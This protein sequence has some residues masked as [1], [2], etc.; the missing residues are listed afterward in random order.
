MAED[1]NLFSD[2]K[3]IEVNIEDIMKDSFLDY[4]MSVIVARALPDVRDGLKPVQ[5]RILYAM[6][7]LG[8]YH[9]RPHKKSARIVG[10]VLGK[11]HPHG[12]TAV[13]DAL[14][15][16]AQDFSLRYPLI[17]GH[18]N[19]GSIDGDSAAAMR[20][21]EARLS[22]IAEE[23]LRDID[24]DTVDF[25]PNFDNEEKE[26][27]VLPSVIPN[28]LINGSTGIAVGMATNIPSHNLGEVIEGIIAY[29][30]NKD[31]TV[32]ELAEIIKGPDFPTGAMI[33]GKQEI[34]K[35]FKTGLGRIRLR[36]KSHIEEKKKGKKAIIVTEIPFMVNK[37][38]LIEDIAKLIN[39]KKIDG[40]TELRDES[41]KEGLRIYIEV[42]KDVDPELVLNQLYKHTN[43]ETTFGVNMV[44]LVDGVPKLLNIKEMIYNF[45]EFRVEVIVRRSKYEL[46]KAEERAHILEGLKIALANIDEVVAIIKGSKDTQEAAQKLIERFLLTQVQAQAI[47]DM[48]LA[49]LTSLEI[50]KLEE[51]YKE[52]LQ[53]I[54]YL[55]NL[56]GSRELQEVVVVEELEEIKKLYSD[57]RRTEIITDYENKDITIEDTIINEDMMVIL[58]KKGYIKR[59]PLKTYRFQNRGGRGVNI[60]YSSDDDFVSN[61]VNAKMLDYLLL[62]TNRGRVFWVKTYQIPEGSRNARGKLIRNIIKLEQDEEIRTIINLSSFE[63]EDYLIMVTERGL[64]NKTKVENFSRPRSTGLYAIKIND[65]DKLLSVIVSKKNSQVLIATR[66]GKAIRFNQTDV[67][68]RNRN[69]KGVIGIKLDGDDRVIDVLSIPEDKISDSFILTVTENGYGKMSSFEDYR[70]TSRSAKGVINI[71]VTEKN[72]KVVAVKRATPNHIAFIVTKNGNVIKIKLQDVSVLSRNTQGIKLINLQE[73]DKVT[74][75][76]VEE[77]D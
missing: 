35:Y 76:L 11:Y 26:P 60:T 34:I 42:R 30:K 48:R 18:G 43:M 15:R 6:K 77:E 57:K 2:Q 16:M 55:K 68:E 10:E 20:Y 31:I 65:D 73:G 52:L 69:T 51:E 71:K 3:V 19:F 63:P 13:Y 54:E 39:E 33:L 4:A 44:A 41:D 36:A 40:I 28:L 64:I 75:V 25:V 24:K 56:L 27:T 12:D 49:R 45:V 29:I 47:L 1:L 46:K 72:G 37:S 21:T 66:N 17:D 74:E 7:E 9:N 22:R 23:L 70:L 32:E 53:K 50:E 58:T 38:K 8:L 59:I 62:F 5:R 61:I 67:P 14:V